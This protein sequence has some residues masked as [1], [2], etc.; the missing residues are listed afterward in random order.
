MRLRTS[1]EVNIGAIRPPAISG[2][3][4]SL[5]VDAQL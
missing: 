4:R 1:S 3:K 2:L 5:T